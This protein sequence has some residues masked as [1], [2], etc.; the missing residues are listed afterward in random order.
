MDDFDWAT[1]TTTYRA[2]LKEIEKTHTLRLKSGD[3]RFEEGSLQKAAAALPLN[4]NHRLLYETVLDLKPDSVMEVGCGAGDHLH[5]LLEL[6]PGMQAYGVDYGE[7]QL[8]FLRERHPGTNV[9]T[10]QLDITLPFSDLLPKVD[11]CY[12]QAVLM[13][14]KTGNGHLVGISNLFKMARRQVVLMEN[15]CAHSFVEDIGFLFRRRM[16]PWEELHLYFRRSP[17]RQNR[18]HLVVASAVPL[19]YEPLADDK[20]MIRGMDEE[21]R[22]RWCRANPKVVTPVPVD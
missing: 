12:T 16:I 21:A 9:E 5:N 3:Y 20:V 11:L 22:V 8:R 14:I 2:Q 17:E 1:Y 7:E 19:D 6:A 4:P 18:P 15:W 10:Q 13:H